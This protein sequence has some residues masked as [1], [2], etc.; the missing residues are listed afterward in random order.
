MTERLHLRAEDRDD[1]AAISALVQDMAVKTGDIGWF[2]RRRELVLLGNR[3]RH[4]AADR[5]RAPTR[6]RSALRIS[7]VDAVRR[8]AW[9]ESQ[10]RVLALLALTEEDAGDALLLSFAGGPM[11]KLSTEVIDVT[12]EDISG[13]W[14]ARA[15]PDHG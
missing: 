13:P 14:G 4:E 5:D 8:R 10:D 7:F 3:F 6:I 12:L 9:P 15:V 11:L 2:P 1:L